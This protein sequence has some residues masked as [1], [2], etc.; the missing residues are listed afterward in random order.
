MV[1][2]MDV[3]RRQWLV[4]QRESKTMKNSTKT[5]REARTSQTPL[6]PTQS[7]REDLVQQ[8]RV[9][10]QASAAREVVAVAVV[11]AGVAVELRRAGA[12]TNLQVRKTGRG[13]A[14]CAA[15]FFG[16]KAFFP[17]KLRTEK[18]EL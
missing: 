4:N 10:Q 11:V 1:R 12:T 16:A 9:H 5:M 17:V 2:D 8:D 18:A 3:L 6:A 7:R 15:F 13:C 14:H